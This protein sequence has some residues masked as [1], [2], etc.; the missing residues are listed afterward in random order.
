[1]PIPD[2]EDHPRNSKPWGRLVSEVP[3]YGHIDLIGNELSIGRS[4]KNTVMIA[5]NL[6][7]SGN[8]CKITKERDGVY[9]VDMRYLVDF[10]VLIRSLN[11]T[12]IN[13]EKL[14]KHQP[15]QLFKGDCIAL[16]AKRGNEDCM[17][18]NFLV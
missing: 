7:I 12:F 2:E 14:A 16:A 4:K 10:R 13:D 6:R 11:G 5:D 17:S 8:H 15:R 3:K 1:M 9:I 18:F